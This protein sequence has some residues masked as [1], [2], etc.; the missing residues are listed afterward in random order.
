MP[1][2]GC[3]I[4]HFQLENIK[5]TATRSAKLKIITTKGGKGKPREFSGFLVQIKERSAEEYLRFNK[6]LILFTHRRHFKEVFNCSP[7]KR[8]P[9]NP[10]TPVANAILWLRIA[11]CGFLIKNTKK[12]HP[13]PNPRNNTVPS[14]PFMWSLAARYMI[15]WPTNAHRKNETR[16][17][18]VNIY[19]D[20]CFLCPAEQRFCIN[21]NQEVIIIINNNGPAKH[22]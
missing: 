7:V 8:G 5:K 13:L 22:N 4:D 2:S 6:I 21:N 9:L 17:N 20:V 1:N 10:S 3:V 16:A 18:A 14:P 19:I 15:N 11:Q 12:P